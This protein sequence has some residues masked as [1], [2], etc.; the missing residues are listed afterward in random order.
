MKFFL[1]FYRFVGEP[2][3]TM[4]DA[5]KSKNT[6]EAMELSIGKEEVISINL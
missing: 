2:L 1:G 6:P 3:S 4:I 5:V